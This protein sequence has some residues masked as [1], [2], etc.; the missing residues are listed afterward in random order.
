MKSCPLRESQLNFFLRWKPLSGIITKHPSK[1]DVYLIE[2]QI[3]GVRKSRDVHLEELSIKRESTEFLSEMDTFGA[4]IK[5]LSK[6]DICLIECQI[7]EVI[8][9][10]QGSAL[11]VHL[12][13][14]SI[15]RKSTAI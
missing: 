8:K 5:S 13:E 10:K 4:I 11:G 12:L 6:S 2:S 15:N 7:K 1:S 3:K 9:E 14:L